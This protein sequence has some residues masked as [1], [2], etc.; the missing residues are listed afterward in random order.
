MRVS[1]LL[2]GVKGEAQHT[3]NQFWIHNPKYAEEFWKL[4]NGAFDSA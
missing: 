4:I 2:P 3:E 1:Q